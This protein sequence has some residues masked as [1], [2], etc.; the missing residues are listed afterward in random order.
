MI[1]YY[2]VILGFTLALSFLMFDFQK[3]YWSDSQIIGEMIQSLSHEESMISENLRAKIKASDLLNKYELISHYNDYDSLNPEQFIRFALFNI[4]DEFNS[5]R[6][7]EKINNRQ[8]PILN[9]HIADRHVNHTVV[10]YFKE[11]SCRLIIDD[12][13]G[14]LPFLNSAN[15]QFLFAKNKSTDDCTLRLKQN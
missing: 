13:E 7:Y 11:E 15:E 10:I 8:F 5:Y 12:V 6:T 2:L 3:T 14:L 9:L 4:V 1:R